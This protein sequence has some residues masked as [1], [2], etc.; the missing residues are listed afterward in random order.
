MQLSLLA[1][2]VAR[3][4]RFGGYRLLWTWRSFTVFM[5]GLV[6][7]VT[8]KART[9]LIFL[10]ST[11][12][13]CDSLRVGCSR[14]SAA[15]WRVAVTV[16]QRGVNEALVHLRLVGFCECLD[17]LNMLNLRCTAHTRWL[18]STLTPNLPGHI[19]MAYPHTRTNGC[20][21]TSMADSHTR[22]NRAE[23][24]AGTRKAGRRAGPQIGFRV[25]A[26]GAAALH[27]AAHLRGGTAQR[28]T[29]MCRGSRAIGS[30]RG[31]APRR[32]E[33]ELVTLTI[34]AVGVV[35]RN[36]LKHYIGRH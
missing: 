13:R 24:H 8:W 25:R 20:A 10:A 22:T 9:L 36:R 15:T 14:L 6:L 19:R 11:T 32:E 12:Q 1:R 30:A 21:G 35:I 4:A 31:G 3:L 5:E 23:C 29:Q 27:Y 26:R 17:R 34:L 16:G 18:E 33:D 2:L 7:S 28:A